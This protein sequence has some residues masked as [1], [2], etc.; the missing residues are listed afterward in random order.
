[1]FYFYLASSSSAEENW[2]TTQ[3]GSE[4]WS[5]YPQF[6]VILLPHQAPSPFQCLGSCISI[7]TCS[8]GRGGA[9]FYRMF[10]SS[11][12]F[13]CWWHNQ[14]CW[15]LKYALYLWQQWPSGFF[16]NTSLN[17]ACCL[18]ECLTL[19]PVQKLHPFVSACLKQTSKQKF[20]LIMSSSVMLI[21]ASGLELCSKLKHMHTHLQFNYSNL[22]VPLPINLF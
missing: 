5:I 6:S 18:P 3:A 19:I 11:L 14:S 1:M 4:I 2:Q 12:K 15:L 17:L 8:A 13:V 9:F 10:T 22:L 16:Q 21:P 7:V 20:I